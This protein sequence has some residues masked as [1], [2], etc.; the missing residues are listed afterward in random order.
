MKVDSMWNYGIDDEVLDDNG[1]GTPGSE[2]I[3]TINGIVRDFEGTGGL[4]NVSDMRA[5][6]MLLSCRK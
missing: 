6:S 1:G 5:A 4:R 3:S 2:T